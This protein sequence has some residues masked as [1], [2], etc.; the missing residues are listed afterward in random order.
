MASDP[1]RGLT[2]R[3]LVHFVGRLGG[4][5]GAYAT[6]SALGLIATH[7]ATA[8]TLDL[9]PGSGKGVRVAILGAGIAGLVA[10]Y[11]LDKAGYE[12][13]VLE[14]RARPGGRC[15][16]IRGGDTVDEIGG[17]AQRCTF[18]ADPQLYFNAGAARIAH[19][20][21]AILGY[22]RTLGVPLQVMVNE[23]RAA[24]V[25]HDRAFGGRRLTLRQAVADSRGAVA[26]LLAK[27]TQ[28]GALDQELDGRD[29]ERLYTFLRGYGDLERDLAYRGSFNAGFAEPPGA[30]AQPGTVPSPLPLKELLGAP[31]TY[32]TLGFFEGLHQAAPMLEPVGG[33]DRI[34]I[35]F[36]ERLGPKIEYRCVATQIRRGPKGATVIVNDLARRTERPVEADH[37][38]VTV[39]LSVLEQIDTDLTEPYRRAI[40]APSYV[41]AA[42]IAFQAKRRFW[43]EDDGIYGGI[44][45]TNRDITQIWYPSHGFH[46]KTGVIV[47][48][49]IWTDRI[50]DAFGALPPEIR[51]EA[52]A[53]SGERLHPGYGKEVEHPVSV[54]WAKVPWSQGAWAEWSHAQRQ[55]EYRTL[56]EPDGPIHFAGEHL[57]YLPGWQEG[58]ALS[59][60]RAVRQIAERR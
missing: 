17:G 45:W 21:R 14:A 9:A 57:S 7:D 43:E 38:L 48:G 55:D 20:H 25:Q 44:S 27:A 18:D 59:A 50:G 28:K 54:A 42:K 13:R 11:E 4:A 51:A 16:T 32:F 49:Y 56:L 33:M 37:V 10:A 39:P 41:K 35:A 5:A 2:R 36:A 29:R 47:G 53:A 58:A 40:H 22:C 8:A 34:A 1:R 19:H 6:L 30:G 15:W 24:F 31:F 26:E 52:A 23:N 12:V 46:G 60:L 3:Q